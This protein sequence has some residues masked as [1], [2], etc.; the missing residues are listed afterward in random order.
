[1]ILCNRRASGWM[2]WMDG[3]GWQMMGQ[4][5]MSVWMDRWNGENGI[6]PS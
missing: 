1:M 5:E 4:D 3:L 2:E 6:H